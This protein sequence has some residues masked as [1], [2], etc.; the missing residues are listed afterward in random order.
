V[1][2]RNNHNDETRPS[3]EPPDWSVLI[4]RLADSLSRLMRAEIEFLEKRVTHA[5]TATISNAALRIAAVVA[6]AI[7]GWLGL[8]CLLIGYILL[9]HQWLRWWQAVGAGGVTMVLLGLILF[10]VL[11][12]MAGRSSTD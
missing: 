7:A 2:R 1:I 10:L 6:L 5:V 3:S 9:L 4:G 12:A 8:V 11:N